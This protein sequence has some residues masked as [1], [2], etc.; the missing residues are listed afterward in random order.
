MRYLQQ[1][2]HSIQYTLAMIV[3]ALAAAVVVWAD[4]YPFLAL[5]RPI[6][7]AEALLIEGWMPDHA[8]AEA[9]A[10]FRRGSY[11]IIITTG[12]PILHGSYLK[13]HRNF[14]ELSAATLVALGIGADKV[15]ALPH[16][17]VAIRRTASSAIALRQG[18]QKAELR[19]KAINLYSLGPHARRTWELCCAALGPEVQVGVLSSQPQDYQPAQWWRTSSGTRVVLGEMI[20]YTHL[21][22]SRQLHQVLK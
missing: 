7:D 14:A 15:M 13:P 20:A 18:L 10:E 1:L 21:H 11:Q 22:L 9:A 8:I 16:D 5:S 4:V 6:P 2:W 17:S 3:C 19:P 12:P